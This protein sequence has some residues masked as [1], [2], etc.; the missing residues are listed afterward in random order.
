M[1]GRLLLVLGASA[2]AISS[3]AGLDAPLPTSTAPPGPSPTAVLTQLAT[4]GAEPWNTPAMP[5]PGPTVSPLTAAQWESW[6][7]VPVVPP[8]ARQI[9][10]KGLTLGNDPHAFSVFGDCQSVPDL[11][12][13]L[14]ETDPSKV[15]QLP[16]TLQATVAYFSDSLNRPSTTSQSDY[17]AA[18]LLNENMALPQ[19]GCRSDENPVDC[20]LRVHRPSFVFI[21]VGTHFERNNRNIVYL[22]M[23]LNDLL[24]H[25]VVPI[26]MT[27]A[28]YRGPEDT[29]NQDMATLALQYQVPLWNFWA[30]TAALPN[31]GLYT[32]PD[33]KALGDVYLNDA[34]LELHRTTGLQSLDVVRRAVGD[35]VPQ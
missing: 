23:I 11:F 27:K 34:A 3:C 35:T 8:R 18:S 20:E 32:K 7:I 2:L 33:E 1:R 4:P 28:D 14:Y 31:H 5:T 6:P 12:L 13:G 30:A 25:G 26:L 24:A 21:M 15:A 22:R 29:V 19:Y 17:T 16:A 9:F 10:Q